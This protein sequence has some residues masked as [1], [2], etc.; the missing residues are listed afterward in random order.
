MSSMHFWYWPTNPETPWRPCSV[1][2]AITS[3]RRWSRSS[4]R[5]SSRGMLPLPLAIPA[6]VLPSCDDL[7]VVRVDAVLD[8][9]HVVN[10][11][12]LGNRAD[13]ALEREPVRADDP[14]FSS[15]EHAVAL[16]VG[17]THPEP[18]ARSS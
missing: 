6:A 1:C 17:G 13:P 8:L 15:I 16:L 7:Q 2:S 4:R 12:A 14:A 18:A 3:S 9:A 5:S 10:G 11:H